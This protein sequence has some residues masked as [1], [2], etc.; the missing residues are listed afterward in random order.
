MQNTYMLS[1]RAALELRKL[2]TS[3]HEITGRNLMLLDALRTWEAGAQVAF[4][5]YGNEVQNKRYVAPADGVCLIGAA[6]CGTEVKSET[7]PYAMVEQVMVETAAARYGL[8]VDEVG[9]IARGFDQS[10]RELNWFDRIGSHPGMW[11]FGLLVG[12]IVRE[13][14]IWRR[15]RNAVCRILPSHRGLACWYPPPDTM[16]ARKQ[17]LTP[18]AARAV[19]DVRP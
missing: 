2:A 12:N 3:D 18:E 4:R 8:S 11:S 14:G 9:S 17:L 5:T 16:Q 15:V 1:R 10:G 7:A 13:Y 19:E 6:M